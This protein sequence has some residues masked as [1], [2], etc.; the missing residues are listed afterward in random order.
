MAF[1]GSFP[2][3][4]GLTFSFIRRIVIYI[5]TIM[6]DF[7]IVEIIRIRVFEQRASYIVPA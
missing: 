6:E 2:R 3:V 7:V 5:Q 1:R 4:L